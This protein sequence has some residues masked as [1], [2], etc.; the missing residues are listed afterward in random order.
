MY[1]RVGKEGGREHGIEYQA[2]HG[3]ISE[4]KNKVWNMND[5]SKSAARTKKSLKTNQKYTSEL[6]AFWKNRK[7]RLK[8][9]VSVNDGPGSKKNLNTGS[10]Q[11]YTA[12]NKVRLVFES[13]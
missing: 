10:K 7:W 12:A 5:D 2:G 6:S 11:L 8:E 13:K 9:K 3:S 1:L 4:S